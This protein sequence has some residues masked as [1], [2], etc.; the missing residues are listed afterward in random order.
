MTSRDQR[1]FALPVTI[2]LVALLTVMLTVGFA[3]ISAER[4]VA[5]SSGETIDALAIANGGLQTYFGFTADE[6]L[7]G[8]SIRVN[9]PG[10]YADVISTLVY[11]PPTGND[12]RYLV[13]S[14]GYVIVPALGSEPQA[15]RTVTQ[16]AEWRL[17]GMATD[18]PGA[19]GALTVAG[20]LQRRA[21][22]SDDAGVFNGNDDPAWCA[23][24]G[25]PIPGLRASNLILS[26]TGS[27]PTVTPSTSISGTA[28]AVRNGTGIDWTAAMG[29]GIAPDA[30]TILPVGSGWPIQRIAGNV[31]L[32][33]QGRGLLLVGGDL[34]FEGSVSSWV[35]VILVGGSI[36][37]DAEL[38][39][40]VGLVV[41]NL[42]TGGG[43]SEFGGRAPGTG[44]PEDRPPLIASVQ[45]SSCAVRAALSSLGG[46]T[47]IPGTWSDHWA[48]Y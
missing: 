33:G 46:F 16:L 25:P 15:R 24:A 5:R 14:T 4:E 47:A 43:N 12:R 40:V 38:N 20:N 7:A 17:A 6:P 8:D 3:R 30:T 23:A 31:T 29:D 21:N 11:D 48:S 18:V 41:A 44:P 45:Y 32:T 9:L 42:S 28:L 36:N 34:T 2:L 10:G 27:A 13:R 22:S 1:G 35:G 19:L 26:G 39:D 37:F